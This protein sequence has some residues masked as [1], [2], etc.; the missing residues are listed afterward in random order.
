MPPG[1]TNSWQDSLQQLLPKNLRD[2]GTVALVILIFDTVFRGISA[3]QLVGYASL[4]GP[5]YTILKTIAYVGGIAGNVA[6]LRHQK[7]GASVGIGAAA[8][9]FWLIAI[10]GWSLF[11]GAFGP[12]LNAWGNF[13]VVRGVIK[14]SL[15]ATWLAVYVVAL[16]VMLQQIGGRP[17]AQE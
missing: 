12:G 6:L 1:A 9:G 17:A 15:R 3:V 4:I 2:L 14:T 11:H 8:I 16:L 10:D 13:F 5:F 7:W